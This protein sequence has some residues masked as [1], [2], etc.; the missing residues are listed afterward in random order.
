[1]GVRVLQQFNYLDIVIIILSL[2]IC[3]VAVKT[4]LAVEFFKL[5]G[6]IFSIYIASHYYISFS[7]SLQKRFFHQAVPIDF[8]DFIVFVLLA[9]ASNLCFVF[10]RFAFSRF[11]KMEAAPNLNK[12][13]ALI[14][15]LGRSYFA[16]GLLVYLL[17][18]SSI[19]YLSNS[20]K[21]S[22][23]GSRFSS[24]SAQTYTWIWGNIFS[25]FLPQER[26]NSVVNEIKDNSSK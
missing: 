9:I 18:V 13:G 21:H 1:M 6:I 22:Y 17:M 7:D 19:S 23:I 16:I 20:V 14:L 25:K 8:V 12:Y 26:H 11:M 2:R 5:L 3:Y 4:G 15:G 24:V 10:L